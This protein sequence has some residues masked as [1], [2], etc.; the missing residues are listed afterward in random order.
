MS[1]HISHSRSLILK[2]ALET[3]VLYLLL[4]LSFNRD[5]KQ[6]VNPQSLDI[7]LG[8]VLVEFPQVKDG[9]HDT[10]QIDKDP[11]G[12]EDIVS[13]GPLTVTSLS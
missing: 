12:I 9:Q 7:R 3:G 10:E 6:S 2:Y 1:A 13:V 4:I 5:R 8:E 11:D